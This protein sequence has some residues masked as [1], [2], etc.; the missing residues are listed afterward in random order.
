[1][2]FQNFCSA[3]MSGTSG[4]YNTTGAA[5]G[6]VLLAVQAVEV[7]DGTHKVPAALHHRVHGASKIDAAVIH[8][9]G[10]ATEKLPA[11]RSTP[12]TVHKSFQLY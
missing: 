4:L 1:M 6:V 3:D 2:L 8:I 11:R 9:A 12:E 7:R 5:A 10:V